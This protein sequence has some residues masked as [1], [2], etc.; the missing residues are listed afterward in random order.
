MVDDEQNENK[1]SANFERARM[2]E[3]NLAG[4]NFQGSNFR[5]ADLRRV[6]S[7]EAIFSDSDLRG[8]NLT[9]AI[10]VNVTARN[11]N[12][13]GSSLNNADL[14]ESDFSYSS[15]VGA[16]LIRSNCRNANFNYAKVLGADFADA[17]LSESTFLGADLTDSNL[18]FAIVDGVNFQGVQGL[19][20][21]QA[22]SVH[23]AE[24][25]IWPDH[26]QPPKF[27]Q[28]VSPPGTKSTIELGSPTVIQGSGSGRETSRD[29]G[30]GSAVEIGQAS[31]TDS[32]GRITVS[33]QLD[34]VV[35]G[36]GKK[37]VSV[38]SEAN[39]TAQELI[40]LKSKLEMLRGYDEKDPAKHNFP[41]V[42]LTSEELAHVLTVVEASIHLTNAPR[43]D[44]NLIEALRRLRNVIEEFGKLVKATG[45]TTGL[46]GDLALRV[47]GAI[48]AI[49]LL[50]AVL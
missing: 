1:E 47:L 33:A 25:T 30:S 31:E 20:Q 5:H 23:S 29:S 32:A 50:L 28:N 4:G 7:N 49:D 11:A 39:H 10:L 19:T 26:I 35:V 21:K 9:E 2:G 16:D 14:S 41:E 3:A 13:K 37:R 27:T 40:G 34:A 43:F 12:F 15:F 17:D 42:P 18:R 8:T 36:P 24:G 6:R 48:E 45:I 44:H 46:V 38:A 22:N